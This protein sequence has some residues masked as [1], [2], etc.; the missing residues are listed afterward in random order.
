[1]A[2]SKSLDGADLEEVATAHLEDGGPADAR[3]SFEGLKQVVSEHIDFSE[4][5]HTILLRYDHVKLRCVHGSACHMPP[6]AAVI[7]SS[8]SFS[9]RNADIKS[10]A[11][12][13]QLREEGIEQ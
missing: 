9:E 4:G 6:S 1:M 12:R 11:A 2:T 13:G 8:V 10:Q 7:E 5:V 3:A